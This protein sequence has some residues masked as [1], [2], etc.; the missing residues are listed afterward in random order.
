MAW[1]F[2]DGIPMY[3]QIVQIFE[4]KIV[5][6]EYSMGEKIPSVRDLAVEAGVNPNTMQRALSTLEMSGLLHTERT[7]GRFVTEDREIIDNLK[8]KK[9]RECVSQFFKD[10]SAFGLSRQDIIDAVTE[11]EQREE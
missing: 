8:R 11:W 5:S 7:N 6:G 10:M 3:R 9:C 1:K 2:K 4:K